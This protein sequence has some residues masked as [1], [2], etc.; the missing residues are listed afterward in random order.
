MDF[1]RQPIIETVLTPREGFKL[2]VRNSKGID[3]EEYLVDSLEIVSFGP[4]LFFRSLERPK[5]FLLPVT[6]Y[7]VLE[8]RDTKVNLKYSFSDKGGIKIATKDKGATKSNASKA[9]KSTEEEGVSS[10]TVDKKKD[11]KK[12]RKRKSASED[13]SKNEKKVNTSEDE[14]KE[15]QSKGSAKVS[16]TNKKISNKSKDQENKNTVKEV[17]NEE[18]EK[19]KSS[20]LIPPPNLISTQIKLQ[21]MHKKEDLSKDKAEM[22]LDIEKPFFLQG[23]TESDKDVQS[24]PK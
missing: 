11:R 8:S 15:T 23:T 22:P 14:V 21:E 2:V 19:I 7:E 18:V 16:D 1:T 6:D 5:G 3:Q 24:K 4:A 20:L 13:T 12:L 17:Y 9:D 10:L